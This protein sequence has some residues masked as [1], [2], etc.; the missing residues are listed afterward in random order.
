MLR[1]LTLADA[2]TGLTLTQAQNWSHQ[3]HDW[4]LALRLGQGV[5]EVDEDGALVGTA[6]RWDY[7]TAL[8]TIGLVVVRPDRQ[9][10]GIGRR[11]MQALIESAGS[12][13]LSLV[14]TQA[15]LKLYR[16]LGFADVG[17]IE[18]WQGP[19]TRLAP[20]ST[21][22][23]RIRALQATDLHA[24]VS[25][26]RAALGANRESLIAAVWQESQRGF[27]AERDSQ[28][29][30]FA[31]LRPAGRGT[32]IGPVIAESE[33]VAAAV[34]AHALTTVE[35][36]GRLDVPGGAHALQESLAAAGLRCVDRVTLMRRG[37]APPAHGSYAR[38]ALVSQAFG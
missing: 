19:A 34:A 5:G 15:G 7:G 27:V 14:A 26:D 29:C 9:G 22:H 32:T 38:Y 6:I 24:A 18:Q 13:T 4:S 17:P 16:E 21:N 8:A 28:P 30:G 12:R 10:R 31:L 20:P 36:L 2:A 3:L 33:T 35:G 37:E 25:M 1:A 11:L 23:F